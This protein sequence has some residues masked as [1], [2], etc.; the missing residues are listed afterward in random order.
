MR[1]GVHDMRVSVWAVFVMLLCPA[2]ICAEQP[3]VF[4]LPRIHARYTMHTVQAKNF[5]V[6]E[7]FSEAEAA[8]RDA[9]KLFPF[10]SHG[11]YNLSCV[12]A[13]QDKLDEA[14][15]TLQEAIKAGFRDVK[16][17]QTDADLTPLRARKEFAELLKQAETAAPISRGPWQYKVE[18]AVVE[19]GIA[20]VSELNTAYEMKSSLLFPQFKFTHKPPEEVV[21]GHGDAG[22][23]IQQWYAK[24]TAAGNYGDLYDNHD[25]DHSNMDYAS[26]PQ[27][28][29]V[30][31]DDAA[32]KLGLHHGFQSQFFFN[33]PTI[34]NSSTALTN[35]PFWRCQVRFAVTQ[36]RGIDLLAL[37]YANNMLYFYPEH[38]DHDPGHNGTEGGYGD[39]LPVNAPY[40]L[41]SQGSSGSDRPFMHAVALMLAALPPEVK[42]ELVKQRTLMPTI[43]MLFRAN[44]KRVIT[45][46][47]Y[48]TGKAHPT[49]FEA[50][51]LDLP[52]LVQA[53]HALTLGKLPPQ[54][55]IKVLE[56]DEPVPGI[57]YPDLAPRERLADTPSAIARVI[58][59][60]QYERRF[61][62][63]AEGSVDPQQ[64]PLKYHCV[65]L[66]GDPALIQIKPLNDAGSRVEVRVKYH[67]R[68]PIEPGSKME[69]NRVDIGFFTQNSAH[70]SP[71]AFLSLNYLD[72]HKR[73]YDAEGKVV[74]IDYADPETSKNY[75]DPLL[76]VK[77]NWRDDYHYAGT[78]WLGWTRTQ[79]GSQQ[80]F[81]WDG[82]LIRKRDEQSRP[83]EASVVR[84]QI[85]QQPNQI[86]ELVQVITNEQ[87][88]YSYEGNAKVGKR[89]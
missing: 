7:K 37:Q 4:E 6:Q 25:T 36:P 72:H 2:L 10:E 18:P 77:R 60:A 45:K 70:Y 89:K 67:T 3:S 57:D 53:A 32:K 73:T 20:Y 86:G 21:K 88:Q 11:I 17:L 43:Q 83:V 24:G 15:T 27:L 64:E 26:F 33:A 49:A 80:E 55:Q 75:F 16:Q 41:L 44:Y 9:I 47:D 8:L 35:G 23:L 31:F 59:A 14:L 81:T 48:L 78:Q 40:W 58:K 54:V 61:V 82:C 84:Y 85:K 65:V 30:E 5:I 56:E 42:T 39:V 87:V 66:R 28:T 34:G 29:R 13:R 12:L 38:R 74:S 19:Q 22:K 1:V 51:E 46:Q 63:S 71:P 68:R 76:D 79:A 52:R 62:I 69:S 50:S